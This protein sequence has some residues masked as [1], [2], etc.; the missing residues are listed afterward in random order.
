MNQKYEQWLS[1]HGFK[2]GTDFMYDEVYCHAEVEGLV[3]EYSGNTFLFLARC[4]GT[5]AANWCDSPQE[6]LKSLQ[7]A[8]KVENAK[9]IATE[10]GIDDILKT[11]D[12][13]ITF[14]GQPLSLEVQNDIKRLERNEFYELP[15]DPKARD[16]MKWKND[17]H[18]AEVQYFCTEK[19]WRVIFDFAYDDG[20]A[21]KTLRDAFDAFRVFITVKKLMQKLWPEESATHMKK[22]TENHII[23]ALKA[24]VE[25]ENKTIELKREFVTECERK[26]KKLEDK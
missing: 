16:V 10:H 23:E 15:V 13:V 11:S 3:I 2:R 26:I 12:V 9:L 5:I 4:F 19:I 8:I 1:E 21:F 18:G 6:A 25:T 22:Q 7:A 17:L 20:K 24:L 14:R